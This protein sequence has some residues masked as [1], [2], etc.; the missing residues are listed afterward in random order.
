MTVNRIEAEAEAA[1]VTA[2]NRNG[3]GNGR[4][5]AARSRIEAAA[6]ANAAA[7]AA[8]QAAGEA[9]GELYASR[10][11]ACLDAEGLGAGLDDDGVAAVLVIVRTMEARAPLPQ[12]QPGGTGAQPAVRL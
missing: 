12:R 8:A 6:A 7:A 1:A 11:I 5:P 3:H 10:L 4:R 9:M 2:R